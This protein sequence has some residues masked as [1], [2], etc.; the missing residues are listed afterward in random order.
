MSISVKGA[1][2]AD[3]LI[4]EDTI[5]NLKIRKRGR[6]NIYADKGYSNKITKNEMNLNNFRL[7]CENKNNSKHKLFKDEKG[8]I[9]HIRYIIEAAFSWIKKYRRLIL[10][11]DRLATSYIGF[12]KLSFAIIIQ[13][14]L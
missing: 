11:Y 12:L 6:S 14:K 5:R 2:V 13:R 1:N 8:T 9:N 3:H 4:V 7:K 10:R